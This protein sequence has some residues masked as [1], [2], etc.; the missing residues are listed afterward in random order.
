MWNLILSFSLAYCWYLV[1]FLFHHFGEYDFGFALSVLCLLRT[2][3]GFLCIRGLQ[4][5]HCKF[6]RPVYLTVPAPTGVP[7]KAALNDLLIL[8]TQILAHEFFLSPFGIQCLTH[9]HCHSI[10]VIWAWY[11]LGLGY[12]SCLWQFGVILVKPTIPKVSQ[13]TIENLFIFFMVWL[14]LTEF[15]LPKD[16]LPLSMLAPDVGLCKPLFLP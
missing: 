14:L 9:C 5:P 11:F 4:G 15:Y 16:W 3:Q 13:V 8:S 10:E 12:Y 2:I 6:H 7:A 1:F